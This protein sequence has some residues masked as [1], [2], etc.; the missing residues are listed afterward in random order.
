M[1]FEPINGRDR[2]PA[3]RRCRV[4]FGSLPPPRFPRST[5]QEPVA[6]S[7]VAFLFAWPCDV[8]FA[9]EP[10]VEP[11]PD[12]RID[13]ERLLHQ[14]FEHVRSDNDRIAAGLL[15]QRLLVLRIMA[16]VAKR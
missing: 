12:A 10:A 7:L 3:K 2:A 14:W 11:F 1:R 8:V 4:V 5:D 15:G 13:I 6:V 9:L 16:H